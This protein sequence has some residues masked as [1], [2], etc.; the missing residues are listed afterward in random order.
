MQTQ[1]VRHDRP[2]NIICGSNGR[3]ALHV[4]TL[5]VVKERIEGVP[6]GVSMRDTLS[7]SS[8]PVVGGSYEIDGQVWMNTE[9]KDCLVICREKESV[10]LYTLRKV[11]EYCGKH[12]VSFHMERIPSSFS[13]ALFS[14]DSQLILPTD[15]N[16]QTIA[17][18]E[19]CLQFE[20]GEHGIRCM[21]YSSK[22]SDFYFF[23]YF[24]DDDADYS[25]VGLIN[26]PDAIKQMAELRDNYLI[27][28]R[29]EGLRSIRFTT[30]QKNYQDF[31]DALNNYKVD[32][33]V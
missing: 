4:A 6:E 26:R 22:E 24:A 33:G 8:Y 2:Y 10:S 14:Y 9:L 13:M 27:I 29:H 30:K 31:V 17:D 32:E 15:E 3:F 1:L 18:Y 7:V 11:M 20:T 28:L 19:V 21:V 25:N 5:I 16:N 12:N 23:E